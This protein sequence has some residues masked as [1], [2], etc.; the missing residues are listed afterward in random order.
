MFVKEIN[1]NQSNMDM[2][3]SHDVFCQYHKTSIVG[4]LANIYTKYSRNILS[5]LCKDN[6]A[7]FVH[8]WLG[9]FIALKEMKKSDKWRG[10]PGERDDINPLRAGPGCNHCLSFL[11]GSEV[12][13]HHSI[14]WELTLIWN[15]FHLMLTKLCRATIQASISL[16][17]YTILAVSWTWWRVELGSK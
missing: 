1:I 16:S 12:P 13:H 4:A 2:H 10:K 11:P 15:Y 6:M 14:A 3:H 17:T 5:F 7:Y 9:V 8:I